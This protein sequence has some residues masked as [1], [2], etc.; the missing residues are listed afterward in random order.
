ML[1]SPHR[2]FLLKIA[3]FQRICSEMVRC[4]CS[5]K[6]SSHEQHCSHCSP[7]FLSTRSRLQQGWAL[8]RARDPHASPFCHRQSTLLDPQG[9]R[10][11]ICTSS[12]VLISVPSSS[13]F[14]PHPHIVA[15][16]VSCLPL[17]LVN[18]FVEERLWMGLKVKSEMKASREKS[19]PPLHLASPQPHCLSGVG[20]Q[21][22]NKSK[23]RPI[24]LFTRGF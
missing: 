19:S 5:S 23:Y 16:S 20:R 8:G 24:S 15:S 4:R 12:P 22:P 1:V 3:F 17:S 7:T 13:M 9:W 2:Q 10:G 11:A 21:L 6:L 18:L 14:A